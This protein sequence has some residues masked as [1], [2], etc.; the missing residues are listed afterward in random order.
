VKL[1]KGSQKADWAKRPLTPRMEA[2]A[3]NDTHYLAALAGLLQ[4]QLRQ[5]GR[6]AWRRNLARGS[7]P[8]APFRPS[9]SR[10]WS[11]G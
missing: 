2:Y 3:R 5:K 4:E 11:G 7:L 1:E 6:L 9:R 10:I 8:N